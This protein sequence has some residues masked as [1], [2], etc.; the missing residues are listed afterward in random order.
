MIIFSLQKLATQETCYEGGGCLRH[1]GC[2]HQAL[3]KHW[4]E[5]GGGDLEGEGRGTWLLPGT[6]NKHLLLV[7]EPT[8]SLNIL[9][10]TAPPVKRKTIKGD[11]AAKRRE[12]TRNQYFWLNTG[13]AWYQT[14]SC[15][16][17]HMNIG[18]IEGDG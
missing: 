15:L 4:Q 18:Q 9:Y 14:M 2:H 1:G 11:L 8:I 13:P 12:E 17:E 6:P 7:G 16:G 3:N 5:R 10:R